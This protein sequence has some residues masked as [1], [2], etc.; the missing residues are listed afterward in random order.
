VRIVVLFKRD[1]GGGGLVMRG[2]SIVAV[3]PAIIAIETTMVVIFVIKLFQVLLKT[4]V[5][6]VSPVCQIDC[7]GEYEPYEEA[8]KIPCENLQSF[9]LN[10]ILETRRRCAVISHS[11]VLIF[12]TFGKMRV[13]E[14]ALG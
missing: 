7:S 2:T 10:N 9:S 12:Q 4:S 3:S 14:N 1:D 8:V 13:S 6:C 11:T 5:G